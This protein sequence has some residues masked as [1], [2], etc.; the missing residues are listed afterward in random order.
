MALLPDET[1]EKLA[2]FDDPAVKQE[3]V[4]AIVQSSRPLTAKHFSLLSERLKKLTTDPASSA[5]IDKQLRHL[6]SQ[7]RWEKYKPWLL[8]VIAAGICVVIF[9]LG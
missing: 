5:L 4:R 8:L 7:E 9:L 6:R 3:I 2:R 1:L